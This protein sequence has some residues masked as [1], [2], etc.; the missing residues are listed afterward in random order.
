MQLELTTDERALL[1]NILDQALRDLKEEVYHTETMEYKE[2]LKQREQLLQG[3][4][5]KLGAEAN[6]GPS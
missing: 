6:S 4:L 2:A 5:R 3:L 1:A